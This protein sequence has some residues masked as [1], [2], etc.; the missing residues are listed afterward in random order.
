MLIDSSC[1]LRLEDLVTYTII[2][3]RYSIRDYN[4]FPTNNNETNYNNDDDETV[5]DDEELMEDFTDKSQSG[6]GGNNNVDD[7]DLE[8]V[9]TNKYPVILVI[10]IYSTSK[11]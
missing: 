8:E 3:Y 2:Y 5:K 9:K 7:M 6:Q 4:Y 1:V 11:C 10:L